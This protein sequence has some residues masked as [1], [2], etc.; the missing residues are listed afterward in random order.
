MRRRHTIAQHQQHNA[1][2]IA[3]YIKIIQD[4]RYLH[5][6][7][8]KVLGEELGALGCMLV[9]EEVNLNTTTAAS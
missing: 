9:V 2:Y 3:R 7:Q 6:G 4:T 5:L 8:I 1:Q